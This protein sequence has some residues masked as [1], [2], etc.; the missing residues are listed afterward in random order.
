MSV[1]RSPS[2]SALFKSRL[3][4]EGRIPGRFLIS[5]RVFSRSLPWR[6]GF[7]VL[8][9]PALLL[10]TFC[11]RVQSLQE[12]TDAFGD[13]TGVGLYREVAGVQEADDCPRHIALERLGTRR[14]KEWVVLTPHR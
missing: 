10:V 7:A 6:T 14:K 13:L 2:V 8:T 12:I 3:I 1:L 4:S 9:D 11:P 5:A